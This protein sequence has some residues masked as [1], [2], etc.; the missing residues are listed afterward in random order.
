MPWLLADVNLDGHARWLELLLDGDETLAYYRTALD[1]VVVTF[2]DVGWDR[3]MAD[4]DL[5]RRCQEEEWLLIT[6]NRNADGPRSLEAAIRAGRD[7]FCLPVFTL[8][9]ADEFL[10][11][12]EYAHR[13]AIQL[14]DYLL[15]LP[16]LL[17]SGRVYL[18]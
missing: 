16:E 12:Q 14:I 1:L 10:Q 6:A 9:D 4:D 7:R 18:P 13:V 11:S 5:W 2:D 15:R 3:R 17:G 8:A